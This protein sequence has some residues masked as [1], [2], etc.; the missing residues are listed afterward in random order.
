MGD[1]TVFAS[2]TGMEFLSIWAFMPMDA[3]MLGRPP[4]LI[5]KIHASKFREEEIQFGAALIIV[6]YRGISIC[7]LLNQLQVERDII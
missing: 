5:M 3:V 6:N 2:A 7:L 1:R 4:R